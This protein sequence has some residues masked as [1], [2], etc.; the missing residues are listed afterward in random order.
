MLEPNIYGLWVGK[1]TAKG[2]PNAAPASASSRSP[3]TSTSPRDDGSENWSDLTKYGA[4]PT[5]STAS[6]RSAS[7]PLEATPTELAYLLWL[8][9]GAETVTAVTGP[10]AAQKHTFVTPSTGRGFWATFV[11]ARRPVRSAA[12][13]Q[14]HASSAACRSRARPRQQGRPH[15][16]ARSSASTRPI[17]AAD[18]AAAMP[19]DKSLLYTD[20]TGTFTIDG[21]VIPGTVAVHARH[22]R[23]P[24]PVYGDDVLPLDVVQGNAVVTIGVTLSSTPTASPSSTSSST[25]PR[26]RSPAPS[27]SS[28]SRRSA[29]TRSTSSSATAPA[30]STAASSSSPSPAS[31]GPSPTRRR[32]RPTAAPPKSRSPA[33]MRPR[34]PAPS[35]YTLDVNTANADVAFTV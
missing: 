31:S 14:R 5:G 2:T 17:F 32:R 35:P 25:A 12:Q 28:A 10:P 20:G 1:Q 21:V 27:R 8:F 16:A 22:R 7:P 23:R 3:A 6:R 15:H 13:L 4:A 18:P 9:H 33:Q 30:P 29:P 26:R 24:Q 34:R 11:Q 19:T